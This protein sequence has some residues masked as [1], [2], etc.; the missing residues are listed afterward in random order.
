MSRVWVVLCLTEKFPRKFGWNHKICPVIG[1][2][3]S[4]YDE[5]SF[6]YNFFIPVAIARSPRKKIHSDP[7]PFLKW[8]MCT[9]VCLSQELDHCYIAAPQSPVQESLSGAMCWSCQ[10]ALLEPKPELGAAPRL[11]TGLAAPSVRVSNAAIPRLTTCRSVGASPWRSPEW[12]TDGN[13]WVHWKSEWSN[14]LNLFNH[15]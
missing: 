15:F 12:S 14:K 13:L 1:T 2:S 10:G 5:K 6:S 7:Y 4:M 11:S 8:D 3:A 9:W